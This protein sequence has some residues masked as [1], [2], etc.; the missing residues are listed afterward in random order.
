MAIDL[1]IFVHTNV[2]PAHC[3]LSCLAAYGVPELIDARLE[4]RGPVERLLLPPDVVR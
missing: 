2:R 4:G 1:H 3:P